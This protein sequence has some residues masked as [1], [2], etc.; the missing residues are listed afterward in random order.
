M[1]R[2]WELFGILRACCQVNSLLPVELWFVHFIFQLLARLSVLR[3]N[4]N[5]TKDISCSPCD[6]WHLSRYIL[7]L[8]WKS[9]KSQTFP[10]NRIAANSN[11]GQIGSNYET[12]SLSPDPFCPSR[13]INS[14]Q[15]LRPLY[16]ISFIFK[17]LKAQIVYSVCW[18]N[19][20]SFRSRTSC[21][22]AAWHQPGRGV[23]W[24]RETL[25]LP[26][27]LGTL[28]AGPLI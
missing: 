4:Q 21:I 1:I 13:C 23:S 3:Q 25:F 2:K 26:R 15:D 27:P 6:I 18:R 28:R 9:L 14:W 7:L 12:Y 10:V 20:K 24:R 22:S 11:S 16:D 19:N 5:K 8:L 17:P